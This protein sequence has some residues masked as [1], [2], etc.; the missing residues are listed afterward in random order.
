MLFMNSAAVY[1]LSG[2][3]SVSV[4]KAGTVL[5]VDG[6]LRSNVLLIFNVST[7]VSFSFCYILCTTKGGL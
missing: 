3:S 1:R 6:T 2:V 4:L 7:I 5:N